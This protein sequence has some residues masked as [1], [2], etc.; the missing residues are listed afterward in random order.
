M[1]PAFSPHLVNLSL[2]IDDVQNQII[3]G[4][5]AMNEDRVALAANA[6]WP[7]L[8]KLLLKDSAD[9]A[10]GGCQVIIRVSSA[11][12]VAD[13]VCRDEVEF[14]NA[15]TYREDTVNRQIIEAKH[16]SLLNVAAEDVAGLLDAAIVWT[17]ESASEHP[18]VYDGYPRYR[19]LL[20]TVGERCT[21][22]KL[23][24]ADHVWN[25]DLVCTNRTSPPYGK[26]TRVVFPEPGQFDVDLDYRPVLAMECLLEVAPR[27]VGDI[28]VRG[29][30]SGSS[31]AAATWLG[32]MRTTPVEES[33]GDDDRSE[34]VE[35][36][37]VLRGGDE[38]DDHA[39][40][41][42]VD[43][44]SPDAGADRYHGRSLG[45]ILEEYIGPTPPTAPAWACDHRG[46]V[47]DTW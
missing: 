6:N 7:V 32:P 23:E 33:V 20:T 42:C 15:R 1:H 43:P 46:R 37:D 12:V 40:Y 9:I 26:A 28:D 3:E 45:S 24:I 18:P 29:A 39:E 27:V 38:D 34:I 16:V 13:Y 35:F 44:S 4:D 19:P 30:P 41:R 2:I 11:G 21:K 17:S 25:A 36:R 5:A 8:L 22:H 14:L 31:V 47:I 10:V